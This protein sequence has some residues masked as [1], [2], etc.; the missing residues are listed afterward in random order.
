MPQS[1]LSFVASAVAQLSQSV[2][3]QFDGVVIPNT[4]EGV[5]ELNKRMIQ[6]EHFVEIFIDDGRNVSTG[7]IA[8]ILIRVGDLIL[9]RILIRVVLHPLRHFPV[10]VILHGRNLDNPQNPDFDFMRSGS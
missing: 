4:H 7:S 10:S 9:P 6:P 8:E 5:M 1:K 3:V 2:Q